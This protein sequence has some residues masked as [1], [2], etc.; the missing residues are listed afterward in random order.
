MIFDKNQRSLVRS[1]NKKD[2]YFQN[3]LVIISFFDHSVHRA[4]PREWEEVKQQ[5]LDFLILWE[6]IPYVRCLY[7]QNNRDIIRTYHGKYWTL[8]FLKKSSCLICGAL[9][10]SWYKFS[11]VHSQHLKRTI[12]LPLKFSCEYFSLDE[13]NTS[14]HHNMIFWN[15]EQK[16]WWK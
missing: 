2:S 12:K 10:Q 11:L 8:S 13:K 14:I 6:H 1:A 4:I 3:D 9:N 15:T 16:I 7:A 5:K